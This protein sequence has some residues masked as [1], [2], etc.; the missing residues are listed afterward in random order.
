MKQEDTLEKEIISAIREGNEEVDAFRHQIRR[1]NQNIETKQYRGIHPVTLV[2]AAAVVAIFGL[3][4]VMFF[5]SER[6]PRAQML[7]E[8]YY[9]PFSMNMTTRG[10]NNQNDFERAL[11]LYAGE[12]YTGA[13]AAVS[14]YGATS[15]E[16]TYFVVGLCYLQMGLPDLAIKNFDLAEQNAAFFKESIW[17]YKALTFVRKND[18]PVAQV[19]LKKLTRN[20]NAYTTRANELL[21]K[22]EG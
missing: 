16:A 13:I 8:K 10:E 22:I 11:K 21:K 20:N 5:L 19:I 1:L 3:S 14:P 4:A 18:W 7:F 9:E 2:L 17:W 12:D 6:Q 15:P